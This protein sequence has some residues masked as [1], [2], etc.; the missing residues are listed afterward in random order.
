[1]EPGSIRALFTLGDLDK[2]II[3]NALIDRFALQIPHEL[4]FIHHAGKLEA[5]ASWLRRTEEADTAP[6][7]GYDLSHPDGVLRL[8]NAQKSRNCLHS[9][10]TDKPRLFIS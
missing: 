4:S 1:M 7:K 3:A 10:Y 6:P 9:F 8:R 2:R 5:A